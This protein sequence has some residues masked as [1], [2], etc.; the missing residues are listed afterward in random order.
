MIN[1]L[2]EN[3]LSSLGVAP[4]AFS[5]LLIRLLDYGVICRDESQVEEQ[6][7]DRYLQC[8][9]LVEDYLAPL[10]LRI[11]HDSRFAFVRVY[12][13]GAAV[14]GM[15]DA[16]D[17]PFNQGFRSKPNQQEVAVIL[18]LRAEYDKALREGQIDDAGC[19]VLPV[20][21]LAISLNN[22]L[23]RQLP[24]TS[25]ERKQIFRRLRQLRLVHVNLDELDQGHDAWLRIRPGIT[26]F[27]SEAVLSELL[28]G[29]TLEDLQQQQQ[30]AA[31][32]QQLQSS[33]AFAH[34]DTTPA[35]DPIDEND[36]NKEEAH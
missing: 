21:A 34:S 4:E 35:G 12:P 16:D 27:V 36:E 29:E 10:Q 30:E 31:L 26:S 1:E 13:P 33:G 3:Q 15:I 14:P 17:T 5:E 18:A 2:I 19:V 9:T 6:L 20:E 25:A 32:Q 11:Q 22:L 24:E 23:K 28:G 8:Q 7:Y